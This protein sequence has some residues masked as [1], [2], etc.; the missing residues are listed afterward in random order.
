MEQQIKNWIEYIQKPNAIGKFAICPYAAKAMAEN[1]VSIQLVTS[2]LDIPELIKSVDVNAIDV[3]VFYFP[4]YTLYSI[5]ELQKLIATL[6]EE[7]N[8]FDKVILDSDPRAPFA[9]DNVVTTFSDCYLILVQG[10]AELN[11]RSETLKQTDYYSYWTQQQLN[12]VV[13]WRK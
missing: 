1:K 3:A 10:L 2:L 9:I 13:V 11:R 12:E 4:D 6:N 8:Q 7:F 5:E